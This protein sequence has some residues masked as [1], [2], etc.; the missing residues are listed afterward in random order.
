MAKKEV[1]RITESQL[2]EI[3]EKSVSQFLEEQSLIT[4]MSL[5]MKEFSNK[6]HDK[7]WSVFENLGC[8]CIFHDINQQILPHWAERATEP[9]QPWFSQEITNETPR[10]R[11]TAVNRAFDMMFNADYSAI[12]ANAFNTLIVHYAKR[13]VLSQRMIAKENAQYYCDT[14][15][16]VIIHLLETMKTAIINRDYDSWVTAV[17]DFYTK[18]M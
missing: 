18:F 1:I 16:S 11:T 6:L 17:S 9:F 14:Y 10:R 7:I 8:I 5:P 15:K 3:V 13:P 4:E 12:N 2:R